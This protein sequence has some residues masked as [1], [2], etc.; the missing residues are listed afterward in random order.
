MKRHWV[1][2][3][4]GLMLLFGGCRNQNG[5]P[6]VGSEA[7]EEWLVMAPEQLA[8]GQAI[9]AT[10]VRTRIVRDTWGREVEI[11]QTVTS[12]I[13]LGSGA[14]RMAAYLE[15][16]PMMVG[17]EEHDMQNL[18]VLRDYNPVW[19]ERLKSLPAVG[20]GGGSGNNNAYPEEIISLGPDVILASFSQEAADELYSQTGIP[21]VCVRYISNGL[22]NE[23]FYAAMRVFAEVV[24]V[25]ERCEMILSFIDECKDDLNVRT[26]VIPARDKPLVYTG[27]ITFNGRHGFAGTSAS[28]G[29]FIVTNTLNAADEAEAAG[30]YEVDL[31]KVIEWDPDVIFLDPGNMDLVNDEY[32]TNPQYFD[33][34]RAV[35]EGQVYTMPSFNNCGMNITYALI[36][37]YYTGKVLYPEQF[38]DVAAEEKAEEIL[39][40]FL[41]ENTFAKMEAGGLYYGRVVI[42]GKFQ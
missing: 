35:Q 6:A 13:C 1:M 17:A 41:G 27:A 30:Y 37:A 34:L 9:A 18:T 24:G 40:L 26:A 4:A 29:P 32:K 23:T 33:S 12:I 36:D 25:E 3:M 20:S 7:A 2:A 42:G 5:E 16:A 28:F 8:A 14:P 11:P 19:Q 22:A 15:V 38:A 21:V 10:A 31:E 39:T